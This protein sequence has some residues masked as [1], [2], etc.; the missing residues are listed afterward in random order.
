[1]VIQPLRKLLSASG[2]RS[3]VFPAM[4]FIQVHS[5]LLRYFY[6]SPLVLVGV[7]PSVYG[8]LRHVRFNLFWLLVFGFC[9]VLS[10]NV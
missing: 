1:M 8:S 7:F 4:F 6:V 3:L 5:C 10:Q 9:Y 2:F